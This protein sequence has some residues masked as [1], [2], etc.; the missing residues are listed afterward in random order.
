MNKK[1]RD[2]LNKLESKIDDLNDKIEKKE[3][4]DLQ[5]SIHQFGY[6]YLIFGFTILITV[7]VSLKFYQTALVISWIVIAIG[8]VIVIFSNKI[9]CGLYWLKKRDELKKSRK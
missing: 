2:F 8:F 3:Y 6:T 1:D 9:R 7:L 4:K 5:N